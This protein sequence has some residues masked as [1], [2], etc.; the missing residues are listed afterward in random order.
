MPTTRIS[1]VAPC[2]FL[3]LEAVTED[4]PAGRRNLLLGLWA[5]QCL[6]LEGPALAAYARTVME[7]DLEEPGEEDVW[8]KVTVDLSRHGIPDAGAVVRQKL[9]THHAEAWRQFAMTD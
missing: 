3:E 6:G 8:T 2:P 1:E 9:R 5:G 4:A 7:A